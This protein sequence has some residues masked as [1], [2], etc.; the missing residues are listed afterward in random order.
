MIY[1]VKDVD[2]Q[3]CLDLAKTCECC[4]K[5]LKVPHATHCSEKCLFK[6]IKKAKPFVPKKQR[7]KNSH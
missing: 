4:G 2:W 3:S 5:K 7:S 6:S 1:I